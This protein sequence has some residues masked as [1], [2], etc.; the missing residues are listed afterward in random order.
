MFLA[1]CGEKLFTMRIAKPS[2]CTMCNSFSLML[3]S[4]A[5]HLDV[6]EYLTSQSAS[7][8]ARRLEVLYSAADGGPSPITEW[9]TNDSCKVPLLPVVNLSLF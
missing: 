5:G 2:L 4:C 1:G 3:A 9:I 8:E 6:I 7:W